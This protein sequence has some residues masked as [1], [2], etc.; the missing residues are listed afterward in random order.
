MTNSFENNR[1][2]TIQNI[3]LIDLA[4]VTRKTMP[5]WEE[6]SAAEAA[7]IRLERGIVAL[8]PEMAKLW[9]ESILENKAKKIEELRMKVRIKNIGK[10]LLCWELL[11]LL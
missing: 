2:D 3:A 1:H 11:P 9:N 8:L 4:A 7:V 6:C 5:F 10:A